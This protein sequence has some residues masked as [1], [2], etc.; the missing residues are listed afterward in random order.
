MCPSCGY[1]D[2]G[3][4]QDAREEERER[5]AKIAESFKIKDNDDAAIIAR[6][7]RNSN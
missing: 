1:D 4:I 3:A 2:V 6:A 5:C 7:I